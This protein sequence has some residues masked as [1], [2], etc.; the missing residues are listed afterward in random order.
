[1]RRIDPGRQQKLGEKVEYSVLN[2][3][4]LEVPDATSSEN[5]IVDGVPQVEVVPPSNLPEG[6]VFD[7][8]VGG[9]TLKAR[10]PLGGVEA[11]QKF[12]V[13]MTKDTIISPATERANIPVGRWRDGLCECLKHGCCHAWCCLN[14]WCPL[15]GVGQLLNRMGLHAC[16]REVKAQSRSTHFL[17][18]GSSLS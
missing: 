13:P 3:S 11:G 12:S 9:R 4:L 10:V 17:L 18:I 16:A 15:L 1:M 2:D 14:C 5:R 7:V 8:T 6:Y